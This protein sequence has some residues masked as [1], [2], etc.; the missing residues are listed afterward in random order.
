[1]P[2]LSSKQLEGARQKEN[3]E[4]TF[5]ADEEHVENSRCQKEH[6]LEG[7]VSRYKKWISDYCQSLEKSVCHSGWGSHQ[8]KVRQEMVIILE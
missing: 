8:T 7:S 3:E 6:R 4:K 2:D 5:K 1:M